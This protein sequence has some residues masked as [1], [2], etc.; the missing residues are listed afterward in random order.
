MRDWCGRTQATAAHEIA[1][2]D[3]GHEGAWRGEWEPCALLADHGATMDVQLAA[4]AV[5]CKGVPS[6]FVRD[7][8][9]EARSSPG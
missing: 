6:H 4:D 9:D 7:Y 5:V 3:P 1:C 2:C 8:A